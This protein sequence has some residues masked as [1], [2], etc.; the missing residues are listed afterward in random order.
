VRPTGQPLNAAVG[1]WAKA[2]MELARSEWRRVFRGEAPI[3]DDTAITADD[4]A[5]ANLILWGD[6]ASNK[7]LAKLA[8]KLPLRW[9]AAALEFGGKKY[10]AAHHAPVLISPNPLNQSRYIVLNSGQTFRSGAN[11]TNSDQTPKLPDWA[12]V[13]LREPPGPRWP[14]RI[15]ATGFFD[16]QW[17]TQ[18]ETWVP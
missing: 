2:E 12:I 10:D 4:M 17:R 9:S 11:N 3:K 14:G 6:V 8:D 18:G 15:A 16:D 7:L 5:S 1:A 13:D